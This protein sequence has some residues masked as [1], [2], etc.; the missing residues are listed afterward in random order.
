MSSYFPFFYSFP[1]AL[2]LLTTLI[3]TLF[4]ALSRSGWALGRIITTSVLM[5]QTVP[6]PP[7]MTELG[8]G[9]KCKASKLVIFTSRINYGTCTD[10]QYTLIYPFFFVFKHSH[11]HTYTSSLPLSLSH[12]LTQDC[13]A[14]SS[15]KLPPRP[16]FTSE[17][18]PQRGLPARGWKRR[19]F[20]SPA[21]FNP[22][23]S[24]GTYVFKYIK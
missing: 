5:P 1:V 23:T 15:T 12:K 17:Q 7:A 20:S 8:P 19:A 22:P 10:T 21:T 14:T 2:F 13:S 4:A 3:F 11:T 24:T 16:Q 9:A 18:R 6:C